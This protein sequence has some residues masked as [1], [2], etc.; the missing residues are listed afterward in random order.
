MITMDTFRIRELRMAK[1]M[2][3]AEFAE[4]LGYS[5][6]SAIAMWETGQRKPPSDKLPEIA[7]VL[8]CG[9]NDLYS[10]EHT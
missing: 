9:I 4:R 7:R 10:H 2:T 6:N 8:E 3:Q 5:S 1:N